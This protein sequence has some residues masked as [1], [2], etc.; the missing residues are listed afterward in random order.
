MQDDRRALDDRKTTILAA[1][2]QDHALA[3]LDPL[4]QRQ[5]QRCG[6]LGRT[7]DPADKAQHGQNR[8]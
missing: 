4:I 1:V 8:K 7:G 5:G 3:T 6:N 2:V